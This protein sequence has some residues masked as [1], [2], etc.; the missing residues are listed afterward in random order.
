[1][2][3]V[4]NT[5]IQRFCQESKIEMPNIQAL[6]E[7]FKNELSFREKWKNF[8]A[9]FEQHPALESLEPYGFDLLLAHYI[10]SENS[11]LP[12]DYFE[13][14]EWAD[15]EDEM[16]DR[17]SE[18]LNLLVYLE[19]CKMNEIEPELDDF[20]H[21]FLL[22][23]EDEFQDEHELY[24]PLIILQG[25]IGE[26]ADTLIKACHAVEANEL[27]PL[28]TVLILFFNGEQGVPKLL[29]PLEAGLLAASQLAQ[30]KGL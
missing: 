17:G 10:G 7:T 18:W 5:L 1:M 23:E 21:D 29:N 24:E 15:I 22:V 27:G 28:L 13:S 30:E 8:E 4:L 16:G 2:S 9:W 3:T 14:E 20:L 26:D 6:E 25:S 11:N 19:D 12:E